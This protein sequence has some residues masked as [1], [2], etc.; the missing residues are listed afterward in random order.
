MTCTPEQ[1]IDD[2]NL[3]LGVRTDKYGYFGPFDKN[4]AQLKTRQ[5]GKIFSM[6]YVVSHRI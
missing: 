4:R 1:Q 6:M 2:N 5:K 3:R